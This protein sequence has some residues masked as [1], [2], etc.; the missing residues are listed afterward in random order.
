MHWGHATSKDLI[1]WKQ[2][3]I[4]LYPDSL[5]YIFSGSIVIDKNNTSSLSTNGK[6]VLVAIFTQ[7]DPEGEKAKKNNFQNQSLA[8]SNDEGKTW[9]KYKSNPVLKNPGIT[10]FRDPKVMWYEAGKKWIMTLAVKDRIAFYSSHNL[11]NWDNESEFG[12]DAGAHGGVWECPDLIPFD[13]NGKQVWLLIANINPGGPNG[14]S[15]TQY[16]VGDFDGKTFTPFNTKTK[17][18]D[19]G[20]DEYAGITWN[21]TDPRK[22]FFGWMS[23]WAYGQ[24]VPTQAWRSAMTLPREINLVHVNDDIYV[25][26]KAVSELKNIAGKTQESNNIIFNDQLY[27]N[28]TFKNFQLPCKIEMSLPEAKSFSLNFSNE[29]NETLVV[30][31]DDAKKQYYINRENSGETDFEKTFSTV[32]TAPRITDTKNMNLT[33]VADVSSVEIFADDGLSVMTA[34]C[35]PSSPFSQLY[36]KTSGSLTVN[37]LSYTPLRSIWK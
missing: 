10:D 4:A 1:H 17:W 18:L 15:A 19:Y 29:K 2:Q 37:K 23:N 33:I 13:D 5:G 9:I 8:Y 20:P 34:I 36:L 6:P 16:F 22:I 28:L 3:P 26:S 32:R 12:K 11:I 27:V 25:A 31:Y 14:G 24:V 21:N 30:G 7:H 35:F